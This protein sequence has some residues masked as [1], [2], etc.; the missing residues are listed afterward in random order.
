MHEFGTNNTQGYAAHPTAVGHLKSHRSR[1][2]LHYLHWHRPALA[3]PGRPA[4]A[5]HFHTRSLTHSCTSGPRLHTNHSPTHW[6]GHRQH[7]HTLAHTLGFYRG[8]QEPPPR[9]AWSPNLTPPRQR[10]PTRRLACEGRR[11]G[12]QV[13]QVGRWGRRTRG[14]Q[15]GPKALGNPKRQK[16]WRPFRRPT[17]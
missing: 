11:G 3:T 4:H 9:V 14:G 6:P 1:V 17:S 5:P 10:V 2:C 16:W 13:S 12:R 15:Q 7:L 8:R